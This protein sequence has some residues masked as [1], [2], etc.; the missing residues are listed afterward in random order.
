MVLS[1]LADS[2][3]WRKAPTMIARIENG[4][5]KIVRQGELQL[6]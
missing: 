3:E 6:I 5:I 2:N 1:E 4:T